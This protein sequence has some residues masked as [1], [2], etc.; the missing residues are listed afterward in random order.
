[1]AVRWVDRVPTNAN[2]M[3]IT[4]ENGSAFFAK[5]ERADNPTV[6]GTPVNAANLNAMQDAVALSG[7]KFVYVSTAGSDRGGDGSQV[8][9][10]ATITKA[11]S[12][13]PKNLNG[14]SATIYVAAGTYAESVLI[15]N[16]GNGT[17]RIAGE[18]GATV[19]VNGIE[20]NN[21]KLAEIANVSLNISGGFFH[22]VSSG[23][24]VSSPVVVSGAVYGVYATNF[25]DVLFASALTV[26]DATNY[27][28]VSTSGS[29]VY[30]TTI[31]GSGNR[32][33]FASTLGGFC[34]FGVDAS[35][36]TGAQYFTDT[37][38]RVYSG[39]QASIP[40]F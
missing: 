12:V 18:V 39:S 29:R 2:R 13:L 20:V 23:I 24:R 4:P 32:V 14:F 40:S 3:K 9:P 21:V 38:G 31:K 1:M 16:F 27:A 35:S 6:V 17:V 36:V 26:H 37:G 30:V 7:H 19:T 8:K 33:T 5:V 28:V 22:I 15:S 10:Y 34:A 11:L 25:S